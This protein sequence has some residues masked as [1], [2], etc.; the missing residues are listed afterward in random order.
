MAKQEYTASLSRSKGRSNWCVIFRH[1]LRMTTDGRPGR[2]VRRGLGTTDDDEAQGLVDQLNEILTEKSMWTPAAKD[3][4]E[5]KYDKRIVAAFYDKLTP[6]LHDSKEVRDKILPLPGKEDG[7]FKILFLG[8]TGS[9]KTTIVRQLIGT[10]P[11]K[12]RFPSIAPARTTICDIEIITD[13]GQFKAVITF[14]PKDKVRLYIEECVLDAVMEHVDNGPTAKVAK[15]FLEH[16]DLRFRLSYILGSMQLLSRIS[17]EDELSDE[18]EEDTEDE[19][20]EV[21]VTEEDIDKLSENLQSYIDRI[22][23]LADY[24]KEKLIK[25]LNVS[26]EEATKDWEDFQELLEYQLLDQED[27][28]E[29]VDEVIDDVESRFKHVDKG[30][31]DF[32]QDG[33]PSHWEF[34]TE[35]RTEFIPTVNR[36]SSNYARNFGRL[37]TP[38]VDGMRVSGP[39]RP[40]WGDGQDDPKLVL[41]DGEGLG[42]TSE[43]ASS[44]STTTTRRYDETDV[45]LLVDNAAQPMQAPPLAVMRSLVSS[46]HES[47]LIC[48]FTHFDELKGDN[49]PDT[50]SKKG[51]VIYALDGA[52]AGISKILG[53]SAENALKKATS[54]R[55]FFLSNIQKQLSP[56]AQLTRSEL[57]KM[58]ECAERVAN[59]ELAEAATPIYDVANLV[60]SIQKA[61]QNFHHPW[62]ARLGVQSHPGVSKEHWARIKALSRWLGVL[63]EDEYHTLRPVADLIARLSEHLS[64]FLSEPLRW[65]PVNPDE[66]SKREAID[67]VEREVFKLLHDF[68]SDRLFINKASEWSHAYYA[69][70]GRG[71]TINRAFDIRNI[72]DSAAP[73]PGEIPTPDAN[74]F[75][76]EVRK[77]VKDSI[78][79]G[80]GNMVAG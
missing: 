55:V 63:G 14:F 37:L 7:Y 77:L 22:Q 41:L 58:L 49:L 2:R 10:H 54:D 31:L 25:D 29:L 70:R 11:E 8:T 3:L 47:K 26:E 35:D 60:L 48:C 30:T 69:H 51:H 6:A 46:G 66:D 4:A 50:A 9:G 64:M 16:K 19:Q 75:L 72:Y 23:A 68:T 73:I 1:P 79:A 71:S 57:K 13:T 56:Q 32:G 21:L 38:L 78:Q 43:S 28:H 65:Q 33:W 18:D 36:F 76:S 59:P 52:I 42:H 24:S 12:E 34:E 62:R 53:R 44:I 15:R 20:V 45:I 67:R 27:F 40:E 61:T 74:K 17:N 5:R 80:G 39:F